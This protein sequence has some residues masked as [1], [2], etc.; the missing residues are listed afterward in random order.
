M[1]KKPSLMDAYG[2]GRYKIMPV[3]GFLNFHAHMYGGIT[4]ED[5]D[6]SS[7]DQPPSMSEELKRRAEKEVI[8]AAK[9]LDREIQAAS[10]PLTRGEQRLKMAIYMLHKANSISGEYRFTI[11]RDKK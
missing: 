8:E 2:K 1:L 10:R 9:E 5:W 4:K 6:V 11:P 3:L 7:Y